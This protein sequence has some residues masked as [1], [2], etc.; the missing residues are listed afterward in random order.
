MRC[1]NDFLSKR[2]KKISW[3][4]IR[5]SMSLSFN[6]Y[7]THF[8]SFWIFPMACKRLEIVPSRLPM[9]LPIV[10]GFELYLRKNGPEKNDPREKWS[11]EKRSP[12][13]WSTKKMARKKCPQK[14]VLRQK[15]AR[16]SE[17]FFYFYRLIPL[18]T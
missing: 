10:L 7:G 15:N 5:L 14:I 4:L 11:P 6:S 16:K 18:H 9:L 3:V 13:K 17:R 2:S 8:P 12:K 1:K